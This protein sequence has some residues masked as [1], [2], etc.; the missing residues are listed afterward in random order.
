MHKLLEYVCDE[1]QDMERKVG[2]GGKLNMQ[3]LQYVDMLAH[4]KKNLLTGEAMMDEGSSNRSYDMSS[5]R[6]RDSMGRYTSRDDG[7]YRSGEGSY[8]SRE[9]RSGDAKDEFIA[10]LKEMV[11]NY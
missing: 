11:T 10:K 7:S 3:E 1:M 6:G 8:R 9:G 4:T 5:R 2:Q